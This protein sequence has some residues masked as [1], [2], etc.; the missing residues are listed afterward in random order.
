MKQILIVEDNHELNQGL[1]YALEK[2]NIRLYV[3]CKEQIKVLHDVKWTE[4]AIFN[5][6]DNAVKY[7]DYGGK[8]KIRA[9]K[10]ELFTK[11][12]IKDTGK[13]IAPDRQAQIFQ[14]FYRE[15]EVHNK[16]ILK[17][18][19]KKRKVQIS[20]CICRINSRVNKILSNYL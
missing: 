15:P 7:T 13:G 4:E 8:I 3:E 14:R 2:E 18:N 16:D 11:I 9:T 10:Q 5:V 1:A 12:S 17:F 19:Q 6:L 20:E